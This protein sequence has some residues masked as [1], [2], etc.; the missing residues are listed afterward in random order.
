MMSH[1]GCRLYD[2]KR[3]NVN[4]TLISCADCSG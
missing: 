2:K 4:A 3:R 1:Y